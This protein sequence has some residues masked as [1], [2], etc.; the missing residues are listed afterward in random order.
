MTPEQKSYLLSQ[1]SILLDQMVDAP[2]E[3]KPVEEGPR[4]MLTIQE[5]V[6]TIKGLSAH[7]LRLLIAKGEIKSFRTGEGKTGKIL[8]PKTSLL[9]YF[10]RL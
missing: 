3:P 10:D 9:A 7:S 5:C 1:F 6:Q 2:S 8:V 4:E